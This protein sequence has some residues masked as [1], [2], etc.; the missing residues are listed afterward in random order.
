MFKLKE[1]YLTVKNI[2]EGELTVKKSRFIASVSP[3]QTEDEAISFINNIK[4]KYPDARHNVYAYIVEEN[5]VMRYSDDGEPAGTGG[6]PVLDFL[7]KEQLT[8]LAVVVTRYFGGILLGTGGLV[9]AYSSAAKEGVLNASITEM[10]LCKEILIECDYTLWGKL[11]NELSNF[12]IASLPPEYLDIVKL[13]IYVPAADTKKL[14]Q[15]ITEATNAKI[16]FNLGKECYFAFD[17]AKTNN[18]KK[19]F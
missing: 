7:R 19:G 1:K 3:V 5:N 8:N 9:H 2:G 13:N 12:T 16:N 18:E 17:I 15:D 14:I 11:Q 4:Q 6:V 10:I